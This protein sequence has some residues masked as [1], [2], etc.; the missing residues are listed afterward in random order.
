MKKIYFLLFVCASITVNSQVPAGAAG[1][2]PFDN[3]ALDMSGNANHGT[4]TNATPT[5]D[6]FG[7]PNRAY[8]FDG[9]GSKIVVPHSNTVDMNGDFT[10]AIWEKAYTNA[11]ASTIF[12]KHITGSWNGYSMVANNTTNP[13][14]CTTPLHVFFYT[15]CA[16]QQDAC[17]NNPI[18]SDSTWHLLVGVYKSA[19]QRNYLYVDGVLQVDSGGLSGSATNMAS[20]WFGSHNDA[21]FFYGALDGARIYQRALTQNEVTQLFNEPNPVQPSVG[22]DEHAG[23]NPVFFLSP[24]PGEGLF[25]VSISHVAPHTQLDVFNALGQLILTQ[26][27]TA[28]NHNLDLQGQAAGIYHLRL[29]LPGSQQTVKLVKQ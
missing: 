18:L 9:T 26:P 16:A 4:V 22:I 24:N 5:K 3:N 6:R 8:H 14:Y 19:P 10:F 20:L 12:A 11:N 7:N 17:S 13:G 27:V 23:V 21:G 2:W 25:N 1:D 15:A 29:R 28:T